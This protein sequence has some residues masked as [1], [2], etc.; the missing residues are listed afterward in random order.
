MYR[1]AY[2]YVDTSPL[3]N[4]I[5]ILFYYCTKKFVG[6]KKGNSGTYYPTSYSAYAFTDKDTSFS[7]YMFK[8]CG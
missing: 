5:N 4:N 3:N 6:E 2:V 7:S 1:L 8:R